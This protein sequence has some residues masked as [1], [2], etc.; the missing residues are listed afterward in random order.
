MEISYDFS[1]KFWDKG[2][3]TQAVSSI[4]DF[5][6]KKMNAQR[7]QATVAVDNEQSIKLLELCDYKNEG[8]LLNFFK[9]Q[10][11][12]KNAYMHAKVSN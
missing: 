3:A 8:T 12:I 1:Y 2:I 4:T 9:L 10:R 7:I 5:A 11:T 6:F